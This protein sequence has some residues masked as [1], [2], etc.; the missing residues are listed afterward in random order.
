MNFKNQHLFQSNLKIIFLAL[1]LGN[2]VASCNDGK[3][4]EPIIRE[5]ES[6]KIFDISE[7]FAFCKGELTISEGV[8]INS[9]GVCWGTSE[10]PTILDNTAQDKTHAEIFTIRLSGL[11]E[12]TVYYVKAYA[13][14]DDGVLYGDQLSFVT[15]ATFIDSRD[16]NEY[17]TVKIGDQV[18]MA[19][20]IR[21]LP[22]VE[23]NPNKGRYD[24]AYYYVVEYDGSDV[25]VAKTTDNYKK[26]G[27]M[28]NWNGAL[29]ACPT[30]W[31][32]PSDD[33][34]KEMELSLGI[35]QQELDWN[36]RGTNQGSML[37]GIDSL[38][39]KDGDLTEDKMFGTSGFSAVPGG[40]VRG[41]YLDVG[42]TASFWT[43][44]I[45]ADLGAT[46]RDID[47][48]TSK[49]DRDYALQIE[50]RS[51]RCVQD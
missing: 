14:T 29:S 24:T 13:D 12:G 35:R 8:N 22:R 37:A 17:R 31:H 48:W 4:K 32:L 33:E 49:I 51:V 38:W 34:W 10:N 46:Y 40:M 3:E 5:I 23:K 50:G 7:T 16:Q 25:E 42:K 18:W 47:Y 39:Q 45:Y 44:T 27:V 36:W 15:N 2:F 30:G 9:R 20:N 26:Y 41:T 19:E 21:F 1:V 43:S 28:Y 6:I 11:S